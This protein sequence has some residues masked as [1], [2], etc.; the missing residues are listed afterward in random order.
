MTDSNTTA[1]KTIRI[2]VRDKHAKL[3]RAMAYEVNTTWNFANELSDRM[4]RERGK[5]MSG[6]DFDS[7]I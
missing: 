7:Y 6:F 5:W 3:L 2:R 1:I 4:I